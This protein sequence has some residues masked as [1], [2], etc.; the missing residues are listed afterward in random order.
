MP[1]AETLLR[2]QLLQATQSLAD[3]R[4][5]AAELRKQLHNVNTY[6]E[7]LKKQLTYALRGVL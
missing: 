2:L 6:R 1:D 5:E 4:A 3:A 7:D